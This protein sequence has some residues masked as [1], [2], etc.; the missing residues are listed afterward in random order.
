MKRNRAGRRQEGEE[1]EPFS[2][3]LH[4]LLYRLSTAQLNKFVN[5]DSF[6]PSGK[7]TF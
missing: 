6:L 1:R 3:S 2:Q 7:N 4:I 5:Y